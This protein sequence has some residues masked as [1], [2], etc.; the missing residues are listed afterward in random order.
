VEREAQRDLEILTELAR[1]DR[2]TQRGLAQRLGIALGLTNLY[3][4]RLARKGHI[5]ITTIPP[6]R[7]RYLLTPKGITRKTR[8]TYEYME[9]S[10]HLYRETRQLLR[11]G[12]WPLVGRGHRRVAIYD[13]GEAAELALLTLQELGLEVTAVFGQAGRQGTFV[14]RPV[15]PLTELTPSGQDLVIVA[16]FARTDTV[17]AAL[18]ARGLPRDRIVTLPVA[19]KA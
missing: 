12:L 13:T 10:L 7:I 1:G 19:G 18:T 16:S 14:G 8:L 5:K 17:I 11:Q 3:L 2:V 6:R 4:K 9:Y 15:R